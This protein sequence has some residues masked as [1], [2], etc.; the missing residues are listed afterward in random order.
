MTA[1]QY[2][3]HSNT[4]VHC[5]FRSESPET[6]T[7]RGIQGV[8]F[9]QHA[10]AAGSDH[11]Q[12]ILQKEYNILVVHWQVANLPETN[13]LDLGAWMSLQSIVEKEHRL[14]IKDKDVLANT[15]QKA[16]LCLNDTVLTKINKQFLKVLDLIISDEGNNDK[17]E[18]ERSLK[19]NLLESTGSTEE[20]GEEDI[21]VDED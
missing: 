9:Y 14:L 13:M 21:V 10:R 5:S 17:A 7:G 1:I 19:C 2:F 6:H 16:F 18:S 15:V 20:D 3:I 4:F 12:V 8:G 11:Y